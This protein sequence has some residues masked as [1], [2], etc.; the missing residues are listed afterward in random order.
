M[1]I[2]VYTA[3]MARANAPLSEKRLLLNTI[4]SAIKVGSTTHPYDEFNEVSLSIGSDPT[5][6]LKNYLQ[7][8]L[9]YAGYTV[10]FEDAIS[11]ELILVRW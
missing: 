1:E 3:E 11:H 9:E 8:Q 2:N 7:S 6:E 5:Q 10:S 4:F